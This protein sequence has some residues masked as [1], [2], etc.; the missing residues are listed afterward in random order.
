M[1][2]NLAVV[3]NTENCTTAHYLADTARDSGP[4][5]VTGSSRFEQQPLVGPRK[6][7]RN[8]FVPRPSAAGSVE[9][10]LSLFRDDPRNLDGIAT[11]ARATVTAGGEAFEM[12][13]EDL[14][15]LPL[16]ELG[17]VQRPAAYSSMQHYIGKYVFMTPEGNHAVW[18]NSLNELNHLRELDFE[19]V[20]NVNT[21]CVQLTWYL[22]S[23]RPLVHVPDIVKHD[24]GFGVVDVT[25]VDGLGEHKAVVFALTARTC[26][27]LGWLYEVGTDSI[28]VAR[29]R[30]LRYLSMFR[31][32]GEVPVNEWGDEPHPRTLWGLVQAFGGGSEAW[33][34]AAAMLWHR[35]FGFD[36]DRPIDATTRLLDVPVPSPRSAWEVVL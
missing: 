25:A 23:G 30:N 35:V 11:T 14:T 8:L 34:K 36:L 7:R 13:P 27:S 22:P 12:R 28:S 21:Q 20:W 26:R 6:G 18:F 31:R 10:L 4:W 19:R 1:P 15:A 17:P 3:T 16:R 24:D 5:A 2:E 33:S 9:E 29:Q 32:L